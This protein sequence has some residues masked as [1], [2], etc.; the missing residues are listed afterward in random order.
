MLEDKE[1]DIEMI[2]W[3]CFVDEEEDNRRRA[4]YPSLDDYYC[5]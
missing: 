4:D 3:D 5:S 2:M 1:G